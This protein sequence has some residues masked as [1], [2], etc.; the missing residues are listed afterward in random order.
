MLCQ[1]QYTHIIY[2]HILNSYIQY[3]YTKTQKPYKTPDKLKYTKYNYT[4][5]SKIP[6]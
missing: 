3:Q 2:K 4:K 5:Q 6:I 1:R